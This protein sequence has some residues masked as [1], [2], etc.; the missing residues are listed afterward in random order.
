MASMVNENI[1][2]R[3]LNPVDLFT[4][5]PLRDFYLLGDNLIRSTLE[6]RLKMKGLI[7]FRAETMVVA[8]ILAGFV[9]E[10]FNIRRITRSAFAL[11]EGVLWK[12]VGNFKEAL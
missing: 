10:T 11:K 7:W 12:M 1:H 8:A 6:E 3:M 9:V 5:I 2:G 4:E